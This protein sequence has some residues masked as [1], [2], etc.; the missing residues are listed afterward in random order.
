MWFLMGGELRSEHQAPFELRAVL[1]EFWYMYI[2]GVLLRAGHQANLLAERMF[3]PAWFD[4]L[5]KVFLYK[6]S[7]ENILPNCEVGN[8]NETSDI[9]VHGDMPAPLDNLLVS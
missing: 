1:K 5:G 4:N 3:L 7:V 2:P 6:R 8:F 9:H